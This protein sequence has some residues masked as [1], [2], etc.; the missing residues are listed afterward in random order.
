MKENNC[1]HL[2]PE[3]WRYSSNDLRDSSCSSPLSI[4]QE[5]DWYKQ[6][7]EKPLD[8]NSVLAGCLGCRTGVWLFAAVH[9]QTTPRPLSALNRTELKLTAITLMT[10]V[11][12]ISHLQTEQNP[13]S[14]I[15]WV[16]KNEFCMTCCPS[17]PHVQQRPVMEN[18]TTLRF[19]HVHLSVSHVMLY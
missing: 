8:K 18:D 10:T 16:L 5:V 7:V 13:F 2:F 19:L 1:P 3:Q 12:L 14:F 17:C 6:I 15:R 4:L 11:A 9:I